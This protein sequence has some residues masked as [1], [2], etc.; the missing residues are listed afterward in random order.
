MTLMIASL[1]AFIG[2][3]MTVRAQREA[4]RRQALR[5]VPVRVQRLSPR[6]ARRR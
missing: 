4:E 6:L 2:I 1:V 3:A 5:M